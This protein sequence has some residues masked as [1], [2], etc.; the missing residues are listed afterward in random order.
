MSEA[1]QQAQA[2][3][4]PV[5]LRFE[6]L[7]GRGTGLDGQGKLFMRWEKLGCADPSDTWSNCPAA[8]C[9]ADE[10]LCGVTST[11]LLEENASVTCCQET[12]DWIDVAD[13]FRIF[14]S[15]SV[16]AAD[17]EGSPLNHVCWNGL[18]G[19]RKLAVVHNGSKC[20]FDDITSETIPEIT[21][22]CVDKNDVRTTD[23]T[24]MADTDGIL[25]L[26]AMTGLAR[27]TIP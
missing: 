9:L 21:L 10:A 1:R 4:L 8:A 27:L 11:G 14:H 17:A 25:T 24:A 23:A 15:G 22:T 5:F 18:D 7:P 16:I 26:D 12:G 20:V 13:T 19:S 3:G 6:R 2:G